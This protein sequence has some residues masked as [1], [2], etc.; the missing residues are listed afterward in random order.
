[1]DSLELGHRC[2]QDIHVVSEELKYIST[3][4]MVH[5]D[6]ITSMRKILH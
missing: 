4:G 2:E 6:T 1:M 5:A 3:Q